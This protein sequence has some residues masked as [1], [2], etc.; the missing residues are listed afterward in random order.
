[1]LHTQAVR[2]KA[3][4]RDAINLSV[5]D[6][7]AG[8]VE[9]LGSGWGSGA[10]KAIPMPQKELQLLAAEQHKGKQLRRARSAFGL[11]SKPNCDGKPV[12]IF[13]AG[14]WD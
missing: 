7:L 11:P 4:Q 14:A 12:S 1:M 10:A 2:G 9:V 3:C 8:R 5:D 6:V 13:G